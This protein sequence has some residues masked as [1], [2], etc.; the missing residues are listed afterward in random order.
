MPF[1]PLILHLGL[2]F[3]ECYGYAGNIRN[4]TACLNHKVTTLAR[5]RWLRSSANSRCKLCRCTRY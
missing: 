3:L 2:L 4:C 1:A 5:C